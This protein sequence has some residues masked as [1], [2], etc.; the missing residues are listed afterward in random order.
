M[1]RLKSI[2]FVD[3]V[4]WPNLSGSPREA[5]AFSA[6]MVSARERSEG[7]VL[8]LWYNEVLRLVTIRFDGAERVS[9]AENIRDMEFLTET[10]DTNIDSANGLH[11]KVEA[12][13]SPS[14]ARVGTT[15]GGAAPSVG[16]QRN[17]KKVL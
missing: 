2:R 12:P 15:R 3:S 11:N 17:T 4:A 16:V 9:V 13:E 7:K 10:V 1:K 6:E 8:E 5:T 14:I